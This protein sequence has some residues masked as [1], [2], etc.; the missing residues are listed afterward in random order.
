MAINCVGYSTLTTSSVAQTLWS[1]CS[2]AKPNTAQGAIIYSEDEQF[3]YRCDGTAPTASEGVLVYANEPL[4]YDSWTAP[5]NNWKSVLKSMQVISV[6]G[7]AKI[8][9]EWY[10]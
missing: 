8:K 5:G 3:R 9:I 6:V 4:I 1:A 10:D 2:G 7:D